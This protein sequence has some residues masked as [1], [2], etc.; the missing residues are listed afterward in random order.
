ME[1]S[2]SNDSGIVTRYNL[3]LSIH[4]YL[5]EPTIFSVIIYARMGGPDQIETSLV[6]ILA[7]KMVRPSQEE[8]YESGAITDINGKHFDTPSIVER[9]KE[10]Y[11]SDS[12]L[13]SHNSNEKKK[14]AK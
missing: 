4:H 3:A 8:D 1:A 5:R 13:S 2:D 11:D 10:Y 6:S 14:S 9:L 7:S 12:S